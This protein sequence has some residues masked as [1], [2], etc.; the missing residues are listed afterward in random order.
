MCF[1]PPMAATK[2]ALTR[3]ERAEVM[4]N[5]RR[6]LAV[7]DLP[8]KRMLSAAELRVKSMLSALLQ[9]MERHAQYDGGS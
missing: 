1:L 2:F 5:V 4:Q 7:F 8:E 6:A 3:T 9:E